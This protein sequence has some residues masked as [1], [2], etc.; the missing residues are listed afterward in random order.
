MLERHGF[1]KYFV[2][3]SPLKK[4]ILKAL[5]D[6]YLQKVKQIASKRISIRQGGFKHKS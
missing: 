5:S 3:I 6:G 4:V 2:I 1:C